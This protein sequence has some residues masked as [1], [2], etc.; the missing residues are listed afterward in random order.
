MNALLTG[1]RR[2]DVQGLTQ[3][4]AQCNASDAMRCQFSPPPHRDLRASYFQPITL[5]NGQLLIEQGAADRTLYFIGSGTLSVHDEDEK[6]CIRMAIVGAGTV[7]GEGTFFSHQPRSATVLACSAA[8][9][10]S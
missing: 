9:V 3:P 2:S 6:T 10:Y 8:L 5:S 7:L 1:N 4:I